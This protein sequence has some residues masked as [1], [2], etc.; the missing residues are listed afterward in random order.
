MK[1]S[2]R[3]LRRVLVQGKTASQEERSADKRMEIVVV[4]SLPTKLEAPYWKAKM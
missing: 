4:R 3:V 2:H 1:S